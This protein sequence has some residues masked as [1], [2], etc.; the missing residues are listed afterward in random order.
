[1][2]LRTLSNGQKVYS[3]LVIDGKSR[4]L[5]SDEICLSKSARD[6]CLILLRTFARWGLPSEIVS[7]NAKAFTSSL[8]TLLL[9]ALEVK[10]RYTTPGCPWEN[11]YVES[12]VGTLRAYLYPHIQRKKIFSSIGAVYSEKVL[13][14]NNRTHWE[15]QDDEVKTPFGKLAETKGRPFPEDFSLDLLATGKCFSR[16]VDGHGIISW[17]RYKLYVDFSLKKEKVEIHEFFTSLV[18]TYKSSSVVTYKSSYGQNS[19]K[20]TSIENKPVFHELSGIKKSTQF[21]LF[22]LT[23]RI[24]YATRRPPNRKR[25]NYPK[26]ATQLEIEGVFDKKF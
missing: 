20:I 5:L 1:M 14:Y 3:L 21:E 17:K 24:R 2:H 7:D 12:L 8:Y 10:V 19:A 4:V 16:T 22:D 26:D 13:Y 15:F 6:A 23:E 18:V 25:K 11:P 9:G